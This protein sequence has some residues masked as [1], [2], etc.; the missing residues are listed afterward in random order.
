VRFRRLFELFD[1]K[2]ITVAH[3]FSLGVGHMGGAWQWRRRLW[4]WEEELLEDCRSLLLDVTLFDNVSDRWIWLPDPTGGYSVRGAYQLLI[5]QGV[6][7]VDSAEDLIWHNQV[8]LKVSVFAW[9]LLRDRL[10]TKS[11]LVNRG[12]V[13]PEASL[14]VSGCGIAE[15][16]QHL[17]LTCSDFAS[18]W[19][20]VRDW[21]G[22]MG[23]IPM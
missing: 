17:F 4:A 18:L 22:C 16:A 9:R 13:Y 3:L 2:S 7:V 19:H 6:S 1:N 23:W 15:T 21:I 8:P 12:V 20:L 10:P 11:N 14:C 5:T